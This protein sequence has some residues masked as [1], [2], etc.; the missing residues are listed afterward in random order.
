MRSATRLLLLAHSPRS[1]CILSTFFALL[2]ITTPTLAVDWV[3]NPPE[4]SA[5]SYLLTDFHSG[6]VLAE[7]SADL[8]VEPA[9]ITKLMTAY[10]VYQSLANGLISMD[11]E[12][13][14]SRKAGQAEGSRMFINIGS[15]VKVS[16]LLLGVVVQSGND[17]SIALAEHVAGSE[18]IFADLMNRQAQALGLEQSQFTNSTGLPDS[19]HYMTAYDI[20]KLSQA[21][22]R[23]FPEYYDTYSEPKYTYNNI[24]QANRNRLLGRGMNVDGLKTGHTSSAGFCVAVSSEQDGMRLIAVVMGSRS[25]EQRF[26]EAEELLRYGYRFYKTSLLFAAD[27]PLTEVR[28]WGGV[29]PNLALGV[30]SDIYV[31]LPRTRNSKVRTELMVYEDIT[32]PVKDNQL[33]GS[34]KI[35]FAD[36][37]IRETSLEALHEVTQGNLLSRTVDGF[38]HLFQ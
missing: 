25:E 5:N 1:C 12:V 2:F 3:P 34:A 10:V 27:Q 24:T 15:R 26:K 30:S 38:L 11:D 7:K 32:A 33:L 14:I 4:L 17:S 6:K 31:T 35:F 19:E 37:L 16:D 8:R 36:E 29:K 22:I 21:L 20:A 28:V 23:D 13:K 18:Q 9:S